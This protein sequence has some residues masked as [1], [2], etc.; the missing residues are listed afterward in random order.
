MDTV[1]QQC[2][3]LLKEVADRLKNPSKMFG[4]FGSKAP[5]GDTEKLQACIQNLK[6]PLHGAIHFR[7]LIHTL[8]DEPDDSDLKELDAFIG[9]KP[10]LTFGVAPYKNLTFNYLLNTQL[11]I[12]NLLEPEKNVECA[13]FTR[14]KNLI[15]NTMK[16]K[17]ID[18]NVLKTQINQQLNGKPVDFTGDAARLTPGRAL[19]DLQIIVMGKAKKLSQASASL[20]RP[21][22]GGS[23]R[24]RTRKTKKTRKVRRV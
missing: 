19:R 13:S 9:E 1:V 5:A 8:K 7:Q 16:G 24:R 17:Q 10:L 21:L 4:F 3:Q 14:I 2:D 11:V 18:L 22:F 6:V 20:N 12:K 23:K 15:Q